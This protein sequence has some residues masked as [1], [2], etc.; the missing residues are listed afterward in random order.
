MQALDDEEIASLTHMHAE[1]LLI[2]RRRHR[3]HSQGSIAPNF[4]V[5]LETHR[6]FQL[7]VLATITI[8]LGS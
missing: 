2:Q 8:S 7:R 5:N 3:S 1:E 4:V 6:E